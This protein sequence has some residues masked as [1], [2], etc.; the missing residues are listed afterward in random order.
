MVMKMCGGCSSKMPADQKGMCAKCKADRNK[1]VAHDGIKEHGVSDHVRY[2]FL[3][4]SERWKR[5]VQPQALKK[6]PMCARCH[7]KVSELVDH[8]VPVSEVIRQAQA[9]G[10][11]SG[12][13]Y[14]GFYFTTNLDGLCRACHWVKTNE[15][16]MHTGPWPDAV[17]LEQSKPRKVYS[18]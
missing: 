18:F 8:R 6:C 1:T 16:K 7:I 15:D 4:A 9:S 3:Y 10:L 14:A 13:P 2:A 12:S 17:A 5:N 11:Y